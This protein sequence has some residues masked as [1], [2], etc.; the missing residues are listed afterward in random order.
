MSYHSVGNVETIA[1]SDKAKVGALATAAAR[2][3]MARWL[4]Q[5]QVLKAQAM[6][7]GRIREGGAAIVGPEMSIQASPIQ[8]SPTKAGGFGVLTWAI[9]AGVAV[10][11]FVLLRRK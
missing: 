6:A 2:D 8:A 3:R 10:L 7:A 1:Y 4:A 9:L 11:A 5:Q